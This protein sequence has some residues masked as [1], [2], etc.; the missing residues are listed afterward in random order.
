MSF[1]ATTPGKRVLFYT[2]TEKHVQAG[3]QLLKVNGLSRSA[4]YGVRNHPVLV[5]F[6]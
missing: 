6:H 4:L 5:A 3:L 2:E 1:I